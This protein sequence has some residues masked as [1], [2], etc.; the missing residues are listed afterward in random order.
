MSEISS[1]FILHLY[2]EYD[3]RLSAPEDRRKIL[4]MLMYLITNRHDSEGILIESMPVYMVKDI[5][6]DM[7]VTT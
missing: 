1:E 6:L 2:E 5:N 7:Y 3:E 4:E